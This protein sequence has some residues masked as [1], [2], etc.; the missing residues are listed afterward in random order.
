ML[1]R[2]SKKPT[3]NRPSLRQVND[4]GGDALE[5]VLSLLYGDLIAGDDIYYIQNV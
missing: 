3:T 1:L 4:K 5:S 2:K